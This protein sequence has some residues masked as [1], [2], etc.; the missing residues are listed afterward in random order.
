MQSA[1]NSMSLH[2]VYG[3][4]KAVMNRSNTKMTCS[5]GHQCALQHALKKNP[6]TLSVCAYVHSRTQGLTWQKVVLKLFLLQKR[7]HK[8][9]A[10]RIQSRQSASKRTSCAPCQITMVP[11]WRK[12]S[13]PST[14]VR[15]WLPASCPTLLAKL[16]AP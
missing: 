4:F 9:A 1:R 15:K 2:S 12:L 14:I 5:N 7:V 6:S 11:R 10:H 13:L 3:T 16:Q 8:T